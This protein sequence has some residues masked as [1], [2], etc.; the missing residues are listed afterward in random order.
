MEIFSYAF[1]LGGRLILA[2]LTDTGK[3]PKAKTDHT[4]DF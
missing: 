1:R 4:A 2:T 3:A